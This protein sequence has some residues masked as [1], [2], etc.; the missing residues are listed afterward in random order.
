[1]INR[2]TPRGLI[3]HGLMASRVTGLREDAPIPEARIYDQH[4]NL[5]RIERKPKTYAELLG[6]NGNGWYPLTR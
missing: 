1:M 2:N 4:H 3:S 5:L 6:R